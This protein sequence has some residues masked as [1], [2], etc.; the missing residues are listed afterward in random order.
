MV[1]VVAMAVVLQGQYECEMMRKTK[2]CVEI[3]TASGK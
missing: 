1:C 2:H 3:H